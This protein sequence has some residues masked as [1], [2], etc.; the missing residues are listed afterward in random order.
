[1]HLID[2]LVKPV[3][4]VVLTGFV[5]LSLHWPAAYAGMIG[6]EAVLE[7]RQAQQDR[8]HLHGLLDRE[9]VR[10]AL[11]ARGVAPEQVKARVDSLTDQE[12]R[13]LA[14]KIDELPA[15]GDALGLLVFIFIVLLI[16]D[17]LG[18]TDIFPFVKKPHQRR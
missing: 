1:M 8:E 7:A 18:F 16:T 12:A 2:R 17:I 4:Y 13:I 9:E 14:A 6:T 11:L 3:S 15:G 5:T 10:Q